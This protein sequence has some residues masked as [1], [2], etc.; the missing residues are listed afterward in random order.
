MASEERSMH[1]SH[2]AMTVSG[3]EGD[4]MGGIKGR[5]RSGVAS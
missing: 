3:E 4:G 1:R 5:A 2:E